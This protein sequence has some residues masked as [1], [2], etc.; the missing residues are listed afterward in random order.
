MQAIVVDVHITAEEY[1]KYYRQPGTVVN[2]R[3]RDGRRV[4]FPANILQPYITHEGVIGAFRIVFDDEGKFQ[5]L[6]KVD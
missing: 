4:Q 1:Q 5:S 2:V 6:E 3:A